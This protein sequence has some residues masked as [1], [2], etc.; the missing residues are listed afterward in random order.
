ME[1]YIGLTRI[2]L[3]LWVSPDV[4]ALFL[5]IDD[6]YHTT[7]EYSGYISEQQS[8]TGAMQVIWV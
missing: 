3:S 7:N 5:C 1:I 2:A 4:F 8:K 6:F